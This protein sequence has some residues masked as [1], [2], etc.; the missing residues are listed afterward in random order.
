MLLAEKSKLPNLIIKMKLKLKL[1]KKKKQTLTGGVEAALTTKEALFEVW[2]DLVPNICLALS[3]EEV[4]DDDIRA[5][6]AI[7]C[8]A[9]LCLS[10]TT[11][12]IE[13]EEE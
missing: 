11:Q 9:L 5:C 4:R 3:T 7:F 12:T 10:D 13:A 2:I 8:F 1:K 6:V